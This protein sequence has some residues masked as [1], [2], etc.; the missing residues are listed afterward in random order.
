VGEKPVVS[1]AMFFRAV[2]DYGPAG[3]AIPLTLGEG[4]D[5]RQILLDTTDRESFF[6]RHTAGPLN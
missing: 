3:V 5:T 2:W 1:M 6:M 4:P